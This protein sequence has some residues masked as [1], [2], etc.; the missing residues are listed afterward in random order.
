[1]NYST[2]ETILVATALFAGTIITAAVFAAHSLGL[3]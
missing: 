3:I 2:L 1:M